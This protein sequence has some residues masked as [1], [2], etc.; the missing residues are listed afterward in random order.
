MV[1]NFH[2][3]PEN[4]FRFIAFN[5]SVSRILCQTLMDFALS[6][7][8]VAGWLGAEEKTLREFSLENNRVII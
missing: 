5:I 4:N 6:S 7:R 2:H 3:N 8:L 1:A